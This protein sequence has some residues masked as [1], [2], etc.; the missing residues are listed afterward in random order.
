MP[1]GSG[2]AAMDCT[3]QRDLDPLDL[4]IVERTVQGAWDARKASCGPVELESD[5]E[6]EIAL[7][8]EIAEIVRASGVSDAD[9]LLDML[10]EKNGED[11]PQSHASSLASD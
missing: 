8:R 1:V 4:E 2:D 3:L 7:R 11:R 5:E 10:S 9:V 6:L